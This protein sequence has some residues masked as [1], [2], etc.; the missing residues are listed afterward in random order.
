M[1]KRQVWFLLALGAV[2]MAGCAQQADGPLEMTAKQLEDWE[3]AL[4]EMRIDKN[5]EF[6]ITEQSPLMAE[7]IPGFEGLNYYFPV[8]EL[9]YRLKLHAAASPDTVEMVKRRGDVVR[10]V[11]KG[12]VTFLHDDRAHTLNVYGPATREH[13]DYLWLPFYDQTSGEETY[14]GGRY[15]DLEMDDDGYLILDFNYAYN[16]L[17]DYNHEKYNCTLPPDENRLDFA[18]QAGEKLFRLQE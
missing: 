10:N 8:K 14:G 1:M 11:L 17:C 18:V 3:I 16:P 7:D 4:V 2:L 9:R 12:H 15:L 6:R 13:G 5:E